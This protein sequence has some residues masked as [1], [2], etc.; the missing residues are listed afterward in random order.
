MLNTVKKNTFRKQEKICSQKQIDKLFA[1]RKSITAGPFRMIFLES[2]GSSLPAVQV[3]IAI[4]KKNIKLAVNRNRMKR[5]VRE[6]YRMNKHTILELY[7][8][9]GKHCDI[10]FVFTGRKCISQPETIAAINELLSRLKVTY[11]KRSE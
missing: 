8:S 2:E 4:P 1:Q 9:I 11:E 6:A 10:A 7:E 3:L 5:L